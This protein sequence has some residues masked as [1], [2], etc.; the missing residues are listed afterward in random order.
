MHCVA[1]TARVGKMRF[2]ASPVPYDRH[3]S[4]LECAAFAAAREECGKGL[5]LEP[6]NMQVKEELRRVEIAESLAL[7]DRSA[8]PA[9]T[10]D[11]NYSR[12]SATR[13]LPQ[14]TQP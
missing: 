11:A 14:E 7:K 5:D 9:S 1:P 12:S 2:F 4:A 10:T 3:L 13:N 8:R 6:Q